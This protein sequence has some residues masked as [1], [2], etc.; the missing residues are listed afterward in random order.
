MELFIYYEVQKVAEFKRQ[1]FR[2]SVEDNNLLESLI[3]CKWEQVRK[4]RVTL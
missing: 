1:K 3:A 2:F 4:A